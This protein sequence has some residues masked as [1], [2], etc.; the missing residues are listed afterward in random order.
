MGKLSSIRNS[1][2]AGGLNGIIRLV[3]LKID[4]L[5]RRELKCKWPTK[6]LVESDMTAF[7]LRYGYYF[8]IYNP[9]SFTEKIHSY[10][11]LYSD[12]EMSKIVDKYDFKDYV[13]RKLGCDKYV[14]K[15]YNVFESV[16]QIESMWQELPNAFVLKSTISCDGNNIIFVKDKSS[17]PFSSIR[18][19]IERC[20]NTK[21]TLL[22]GYARA[23]Y[24]LKPRL[25]AEEYLRELSGGLQDYKFY[26]FNGEI[27]FVYATS[28][29]FL[30]KNNPS[31]ADYPRTFF[32]L[33]WTKI[34]I[35]LGDHP[36]ANGVE[37]PHHFEEMI[38]ISKE[39]SKGF[40]FVR[41][42]FYDLPDR[43]L[44]GEMTFYPTGGWKPLK[45][46]A[47]DRELGDKFIIPSEKLIK[48]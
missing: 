38:L 27:E 26:C 5:F 46:L 41:I 12:P 29:V 45:P 39:L 34:P 7:G 14:A 11:L 36:T 20:F 24:P 35:S 30:S 2:H 33:N 37:K 18:R 10:K 23:Y 25:L 44:L 40:P 32:N 22:N 1:Y 31:D 3:R 13:Y 21:D 16:K 17:T 19:E 9:K 42:D 6:D 28:R 8:D 15:T 43:L 4:T 48:I 47:F